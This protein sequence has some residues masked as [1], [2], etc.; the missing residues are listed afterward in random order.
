MKPL[1]GEIPMTKTR[2]RFDSDTNFSHFLD[3]IYR[4]DS[5]GGLVVDHNALHVDFYG[6]MDDT[7]ADVV[8]ILSG[9][10]EELP[11]RDKL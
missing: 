3:H 2:V 6:P 7:T 10:T 8:A 1:R 4:D 11:V 9:Q 5:V